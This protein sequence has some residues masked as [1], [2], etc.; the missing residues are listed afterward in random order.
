MIALRWRMRSLRAGIKK[1]RQSFWPKKQTN[2]VSICI[3]R[4]VSAHI[5]IMNI[6]WGGSLASIYSACKKAVLS[7]HSGDSSMKTVSKLCL[8]FLLLLASAMASADVTYT[9]TGSGRATF[10]LTVADYITSDTTISSLTRCSV[11]GEACSGVSF[12]LDA[13]AQ[14]FTGSDHGWS[15]LGVIAA[16]GGGSWFYFP[17]G[18]YSASGVYAEQAFG[19]GTLTVLAVPEASEYA[20]LLA[21]LGMLGFVARRKAKA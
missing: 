4:V 11:S 12:Y 16:T 19:D 8:S 13:Y 7:I 20:M 9:F 1:P 14:G 21:G 18:A 15:A 17:N 5:C 10:E 3:A 2:A 6:P